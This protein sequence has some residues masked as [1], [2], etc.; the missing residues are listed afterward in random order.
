MKSEFWG[1]VVSDLVPS[2]VGVRS[3]CGLSM[4]M[5]TD[6]LEWRQ[7][8]FQKVIDLGLTDNLAEIRLFVL[9]YD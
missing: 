7:W 8:L 4:F 1:L 9:G 6:V 2:R 5:A 3:V